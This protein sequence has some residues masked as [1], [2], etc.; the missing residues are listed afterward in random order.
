MCTLELASLRLSKHRCQELDHWGVSWG[1]I[2]VLHN[3]A[4]KNDIGARDAERILDCPVATA[5]PNNYKALRRATTDE[6]VIDERSDLGEAY[7]AFSRMR[8]GME[9]EKKS[10]SGCFGNNPFWDR[11]LRRWRRSPLV[12]GDLRWFSEIW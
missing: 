10:S 5:L 9:A 6:G 8:T 4:H 11:H 7:L 12:R 2:Q 1:R 3:R